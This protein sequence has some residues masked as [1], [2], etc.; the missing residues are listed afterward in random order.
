MVAEIVWAVP[1]GLNVPA[2]RFRVPPVPTTLVGKVEVFGVN[3]PVAPTST[4]PAPVTF[5]T[6]RW[7]PPVTN[8]PAVTFRVCGVVYDPPASTRP[9]PALVRV[10]FQPN[11]AGRVSP[12]PA[13]VLL[14]ESV[15]PEDPTVSPASG[16]LATVPVYDRVP[17]ST[18]TAPAP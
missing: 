15:P 14:A 11:A 10:P 6:V 7:C 8:V 18:V 16:A 4:V 9:D 3:A 1:V 17:P 5:A 13:V 2:G 12:A